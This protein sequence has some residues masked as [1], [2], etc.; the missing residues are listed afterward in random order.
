MGATVVGVLAV[1]LALRE[2][3]AQPAGGPWRAVAA[4]L[5]ICAIGGCAAL[6]TRRQEFVYGSGVLFVFAAIAA[7]TGW[8]Q[9]LPLECA[10][11]GIMGLGT[12]AGAWSGTESWL[13]RSVR[14]DLRGGSL[15]F[16]HFGVI[17]VSWGC[18]FW[19][20]VERCWC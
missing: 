8:G 20:S 14:I 4:L 17:G 12:A 19:R 6:L 18:S 5:G 10:I 3:I 15:P 7:G 1:L 9:T 16:A 11:V 13:R 2:V